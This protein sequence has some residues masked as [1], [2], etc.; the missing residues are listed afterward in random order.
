M[1]DTDQSD[2]RS[3]M[4]AVGTKYGY[5]SP[6]MLALWKKQQAID[7]AKSG[8][9]LPLS[10]AG[11]RGELPGSHPPHIQMYEVRL[12][13]IAHAASAHGQCDVPQMSCLYMP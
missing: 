9:V 11:D 2:D 6:E 13:V 10:K 12:R 7:E 4:E 8:E 5:N 3:E 1:Y